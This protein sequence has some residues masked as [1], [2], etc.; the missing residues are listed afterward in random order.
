MKQNIY[1]HP[2]FFSA[3]KDFRNQDQGMNGLLEQPVMKR[4]MQFV[5]GKNIL[6]L[7]CGLGHQIE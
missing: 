3:Y 4:M 5:Y 7:G 2:D 6:D 1:D